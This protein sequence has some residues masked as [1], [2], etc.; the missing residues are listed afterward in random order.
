MFH[1]LTFYHLWKS[2]PTFLGPTPVK[3]EGKGGKKYGIRK[4]ETIKGI[5]IGKMSEWMSSFYCFL[6]LEK[7]WGE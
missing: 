2:A 5:F 3:R 7:Y 6:L 1:Y 4:T